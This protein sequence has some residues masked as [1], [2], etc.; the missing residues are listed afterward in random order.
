MADQ[1]IITDALHAFAA[2]MS[3]AEFASFTAAVREPSEKPAPESTP[4][5]PAD[6][7]YP[8]IWKPQAR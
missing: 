7:E 1:T 4:A 2:S 3:D 5:E 6:A 8:A